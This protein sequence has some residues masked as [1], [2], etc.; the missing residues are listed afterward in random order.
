[1]RWNIV[2]TSGARRDLRDIYEY[3]AHELLAPETAAGQTQRIMK[4]IRALSEM[5][6]RFRLY[7]EEPWHSEGLRFFPIDHYLVFYLPDETKNI[8]SIV[9]IMYGGRDIRKQLSEMEY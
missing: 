9:R 1:M 4:E 8:V 3:I 6:M 7:E 5:P 2:Y